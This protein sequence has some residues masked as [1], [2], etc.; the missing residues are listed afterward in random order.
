MPKTAYRRTHWY[1]F[2]SARL[3]CFWRGVARVPGACH[4][5]LGPSS[6][7]VL[8]TPAHMERH[9]KMIAVYVFTS[10]KRGPIWRNIA[11]RFPTRLAL[12]NDS[13][14]HAVSARESIS[15]GPAACPSGVTLGCNVSMVP[16]MYGKRG[17]RVLFSLCSLPL[18]PSPLYT[19]RNEILNM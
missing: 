19:Q 3:S 16:V 9:R 8:T 10:S 14:N 6:P 12:A 15:V 7:R 2:Q 17:P 1:F 11:Y 18:R 5:G 4:P 13:V